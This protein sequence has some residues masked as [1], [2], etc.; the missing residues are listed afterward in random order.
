MGNNENFEE[1]IND[2]IYD[3]ILNISSRE[4]DT[5]D[6][7]LIDRFGLLSELFK[8]GDISIVG[9]TFN[10]KG[11]QNFIEPLIYGVPAVIGPSYDN[12][13]DLAAYFQDDELFKIDK[14][15]TDF[16]YAQDIASTISSIDKNM[17]DIK[18]KLKLRV[19]QLL[20][21]AEKQV[22]IVEKL[23]INF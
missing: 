11:G 23:F 1:N 18:Q 14:R 20:K 2:S 8:Y 12:F 7:V 4:D 21:I 17:D 19:I 10:E 6:T 22:K 3:L 9:G 13:S 5:I 16:L 15:S